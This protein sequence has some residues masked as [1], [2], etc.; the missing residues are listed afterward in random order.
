MPQEAWLRRQAVMIA[1]Q[2][3]ENPDDAERVLTLATQ[4]VNGFLRPHG[5]TEMAQDR[6]LRLVRPDLP[7][8]A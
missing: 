5:A 1:S 3:P 6:F 7:S 8:S 2:L 4:I